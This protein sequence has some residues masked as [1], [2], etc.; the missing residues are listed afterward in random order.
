MTS[1]PPKYSSASPITYP[2]HPLPEP[3]TVPTPVAV[4]VNSPGS[5]PGFYPP[6][7]AQ[8]FNVHTDGSYF[9]H[10]AIGFGAACLGG[11]F[12]FLC[13]SYRPRRLA[14]NMFHAAAFC[15]GAGTQYTIASIICFSMISLFT[16]YHN[17]RHYYYTEPLLVVSSVGVIW[18]LFA[19]SAFWRVRHYKQSFKKKLEL[20]ERAFAA[21]NTIVASAP[22]AGF[23]AVNLTQTRA[24]HQTILASTPIPSPAPRNLSVEAWNKDQVGEWLESH[25]LGDVK[26]LFRKNSVDGLAMMYLQ[27]Q[28]VER[29][30]VTMG[31]AMRFVVARSQL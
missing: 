8:P 18:L 24:Q 31:K 6:A 30:G 25:E 4:Y 26:E 15:A 2:I 29:M 27:Q 1:S 16:D 14:K 21:G 11:P 9:T 19:V 20:E 7:P 5:Y 28:D 23:T 13:M 10:F 3:I 17:D 22:P 12:I